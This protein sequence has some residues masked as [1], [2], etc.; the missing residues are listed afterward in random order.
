MD[1]AF[2]KG[3]VAQKLHFPVQI[4]LHDGFKAA[5]HGHGLQR[6]FRAV[7]DKAD[8]RRRLQR[9]QAFHKHE[10]VHNGRGLRRNQQQAF[11]RCGHEAHHLAVHA[12]AAVED[13]E[14]QLG[15][16]LLQLPL[17]GVE[18]AGLQVQQLHHAAAAGNVPDAAVTL[19]DGLAE[20]HPAV[21]HVADVVPGVPAE[22]QI[23]IGKAKVRIDDHDRFALLRQGNGKIDGKAGL[24]RAALSACHGKD[25]GTALHN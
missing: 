2:V 9:A 6:R 15:V 1:H 5:R 22:H 4:L 18:P 8:G 12:R 3:D 17:Q 13:D 23:H 24:A 10:G 19:A 25:H 14:I 7:H 16:Q 20:R 11:I 21:Q